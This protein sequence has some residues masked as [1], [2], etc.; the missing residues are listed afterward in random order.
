MKNIVYFDLETKKSAGE[1][2]GW[3]HKEKMLMSV[4]VTY[5]SGDEKYRIYDEAH[6]DDLVTELTRV[7]RTP[8]QVP[9]GSTRLS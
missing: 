6:V 5:S 7:P 1:V 3:S 4:G 2:G 9:M 8:T